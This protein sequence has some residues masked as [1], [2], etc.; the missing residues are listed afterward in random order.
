MQRQIKSRSK[1]SSQAA[2]YIGEIEQ[3]K[4]FLPPIE[5]QRKYSNLSQEINDLH[6]KLEQ[7]EFYQD[8]LF[9]SLLQR[10]FRGEL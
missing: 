7:D 2:L 10:A 4:I 5:L 3:L 1:Q 9:N 8:N 6:K